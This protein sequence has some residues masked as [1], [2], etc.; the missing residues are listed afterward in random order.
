[1]GT[2]RIRGVD[3]RE[4]Q[5]RLGNVGNQTR[6]LIVVQVYLDE[7]RDSVLTLPNAE[8]LLQ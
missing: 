2:G 4:P 3:R 6:E 1:M 7:L 8:P 5:S